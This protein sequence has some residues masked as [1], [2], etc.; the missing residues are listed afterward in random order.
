M[1]YCQQC[2][3]RNIPLDETCLR[4]R[5]LGTNVKF[6]NL[7]NRAKAT[8]RIG[9]ASLPRLT[10]CNFCKAYLYKP[11]GTGQR[12]AKSSAFNVVWPSLIWAYLIDRK[13]LRCSDFTTF[14]W[15]MLP[16]KWRG[17]W[18]DSVHSFILVRRGRH[19][20]YYPYI[21]YSLLDPPPFF[22]DV[23]A[24][25]VAAKQ[26]ETDLE[27]AKLYTYFDQKCHFTT[28][29]CPWGC[30]EFIGSCGSVSYEDVILHFMNG[31]VKSSAFLRPG[32]TFYKFQKVAGCRPDYLTMPTTFL[33][34][35]VM[36]FQRCIIVD[37]NDG[38]KVLTCR[39]HDGGTCGTSL[40]KFSILLTYL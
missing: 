11:P 12:G 20:T 21:T 40:N 33:P 7:Q 5:N 6:C 28:V 22:Q 24:E 37:E 3:R 31:F 34:N 26:I 14:M 1:S 36:K 2:Y 8:G 23:T 39:N 9:A 4:T 29:K 38:P 35:D 25:Y 27:I 13:T 32:T 10:L 17:W 18:I 16:Q 15:Q 30:H 19:N